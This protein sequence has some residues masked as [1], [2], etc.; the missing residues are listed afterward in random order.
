MK[1]ET[2][3]KMKFTKSENNGD[4]KPNK[5]TT[6]PNCYPVILSFTRQNCLWPITLSPATSLH[7]SLMI[8]VS[9]Q[10]SPP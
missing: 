3:E 8:Q 9:E 1:S 6:P 4:M 10:T 7:D 5:K 2:N